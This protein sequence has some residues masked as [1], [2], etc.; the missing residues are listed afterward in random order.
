ME[1]NDHR[2]RAYSVP[3]V[4][5]LSTGSTSN[6][7]VGLVGPGGGLITP[8][9]SSPHHAIRTM[10]NGMATT[11]PQSMVAHDLRTNQASSTRSLRRPRMRH[12]SVSSSRRE[13]FEMRCCRINVLLVTMQLSLGVVITSLGF[14]MQTLTPSLGVRDAPYWAG[15]PVSSLFI[16]IFIPI[17]TL[18]SI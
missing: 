17:S 14:Y 9:A 11:V 12:L 18:S 8:I 4:S 2:P 16:S 3:A 5:L 15:I 10:Q 13:T 7:G 6:G 1:T